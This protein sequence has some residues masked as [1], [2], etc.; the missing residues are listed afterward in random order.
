MSL[1]QVSSFDRRGSFPTA[2]LDFESG[3]FEGWSVK[4]LAGR[5][6][7]VIQSETV[8]VGTRACRF[9]LHPG[10]YVSEGYR[11]ELRDPWN[12]IWEKEIWYGF[13]SF[14]AA[15]FELSDEIGCVLAQWHDQAKLGDPSGKPPIALRYRAGRL[16]VTGAAGKVASPDPDQ[17]YEFASVPDLSRGVWHDFVFRVFWSRY[18]TSEIEAWLDG[19]KLADWRGPLGYE[20]EV[21]GPYF[22]FGVYC[23]APGHRPCVVVH[24]NYS[25]GHSFAEVDPAVWHT[26]PGP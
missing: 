2:H 22:K 8:R 12:A 21:E 17:R 19:N 24:D 18:G 26:R 6:S 9:A 23:S 16:T 15:D 10:D 13:S 11:A 7:A 5:H 3:T 1:A 14:I 4:R 20:N 25:R